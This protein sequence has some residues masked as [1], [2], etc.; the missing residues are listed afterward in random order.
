MRFT[1][2][3]W[4]SCTIKISIW[5]SCHH[6]MS[7]HVIIILC[8]AMSC[9]VIQCHTMPCMSCDSCDV[10]WCDDMWSH[11]MWCHVMWCHAMSCH[12]VAYTLVARERTKLSP[13]KR[14]F[15]VGLLGGNLRNNRNFSAFINLKFTVFPW[16]DTI[17]A[18]PSYSEESGLNLRYINSSVIWWQIRPRCFHLEP[19]AL[20]SLGGGA[21]YKTHGS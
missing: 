1:V 20:T 15:S 9:H 13:V 17:N 16:G 3:P 11:V 18:W 12:V 2:F 6:I 7:Y 5:I 4:I 19:N 21:A 10:M 14:D 8:H